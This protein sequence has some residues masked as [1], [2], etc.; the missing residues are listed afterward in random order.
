MGEDGERRSHFILLGSST[1][2]SQMKTLPTWL[3]SASRSQLGSRQNRMYQ[4]SQWVT[5]SLVCQETGG[6][7]ACK[8]DVSVHQ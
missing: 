7:E 3:P 4:M 8:C 6:R 5:S 2:M 1:D